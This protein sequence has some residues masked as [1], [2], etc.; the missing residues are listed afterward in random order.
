MK[1]AKQSAKARIKQ[2]ER[3]RLNWFE[4][5]SD[6]QGDYVKILAAIE[7]KQ[8]EAE[9]IQKEIELLNA[10]R[11]AKQVEMV[12]ENKVQIEKFDQLIKEATETY[13]NL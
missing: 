11:I 8:A 4:E 6:D 10:Q 3:Q 13:E 7:S 2:L 12:G 9:V 1:D 5:N